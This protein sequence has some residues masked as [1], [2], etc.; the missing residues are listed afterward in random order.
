MTE[1][2]FRDDPY[3]RDCRATVI[4]A[5]GAGIRLD[6][7][8]FYPRGGGQPGDAGRLVDDAGTVTPI[9]DCG[10]D[11][12]GSLIHHP[13][14][15][16]PLPAPGA[17]VTAELDWDRRYRHMRLHTCL[18]L[19]CALL[20]FGVT[21][22]QIGADKARL[23]FDAGDTALDKADLTERLN[24]LIEENHPVSPLYVEEDE[25]DRQPDLV[26][27]LK[28]QPPRGQGRLR[29]IAIPGLD[30]QPCGGTHVAETGEI[31]RIRIAKIESKGRNNR[32]ISIMFDN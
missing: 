13:A 30:T 10:R 25:L 12:D 5:D 8:V 21:G 3:A 26:R 2:V 6:R 16:A 24:R 31:G 22:G 7:T 19:L 11:A 14:E 27:T 9:V 32:R 29:L 20:P 28:V 23:D 1:E 4:A 18:H 15:G 17:M